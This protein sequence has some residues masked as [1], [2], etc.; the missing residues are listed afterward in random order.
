MHCLREIY[1]CMHICYFSLKTHYHTF[2]KWR[3]EQ[4]KLKQFNKKAKQTSR[5]TC[6]N[7]FPLSFIFV[8]VHPNFFP[9]VTIVYCLLITSFV[10]FCLCPE[11]TPSEV[12]VVVGLRTKKNITNGGKNSDILNKKEELNWKYLHQKKEEFFKLESC[13]FICV[14]RHIF[15]CTFFSYLH[16]PL[17]EPWIQRRMSHRLFSGRPSSGK[18]S[19]QCLVFFCLPA[20]RTWCRWLWWP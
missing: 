6:L 16:I 20:S 19:R 15:S 5:F 9:P 3:Q 8:T 13:I 7:V 1:L 18:V 14:E 17:R 2:V 4:I 11:Y 12:L 10:T